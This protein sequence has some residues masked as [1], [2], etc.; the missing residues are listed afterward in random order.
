MAFTDERS[1]KEVIS[2]ILRACLKGKSFFVREKR[3]RMQERM[4]YMQMQ[5][6]LEMSFVLIRK[7]QKGA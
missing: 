2:R 4:R 7:A 6:A 5:D 3:A 1:M